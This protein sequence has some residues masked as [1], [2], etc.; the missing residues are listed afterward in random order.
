[1]IRNQRILKPGWLLPLIVIGIAAMA[2]AF[3]AM[4]TNQARAGVS[5]AGDAAMGTPELLVLTEYSGYD[6]IGIPGLS[7]VMHKAAWKD[8][9]VDVSLECG[10]STDTQ[11][12]SKGGKK[13]TA[14]A[15]A[16][17][18]VRVQASRAGADGLFGTVDDI[19]ETMEPGWV[20]FCRRS[21]EL[22]ATF[23]GLLEDE[24]GNVCLIVDPITH[25]VTIDQDCLGYEPVRR[26]ALDIKL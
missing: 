15:S 9:V 11:V 6:G 1:M 20:T 22:S 3:W 16:G 13:S 5:D 17:V 12:E 2:L 18:Q 7:G 26:T 21:Q 23:Q 10:L 4:T 19:T 25:K 24:E 8:L 14:T